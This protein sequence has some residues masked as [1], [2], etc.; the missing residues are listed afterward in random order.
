MT[1]KRTP[2]EVLDDLAFPV[3]VGLLLTATVM[4]AGCAG[5][6]DRVPWTELPDAFLPACPSVDKEFRCRDALT[7]ESRFQY[8][9]LLPEV[10]E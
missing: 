1:T 7:G 6:V 5:S 10:S 3:L 8:P 4:L 2:L 9:M